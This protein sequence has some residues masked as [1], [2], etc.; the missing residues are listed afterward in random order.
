MQVFS[1]GCLGVTSEVSVYHG[2]AM[3]IHITIACSKFKLRFHQ[4]YVDG[5]KPKKIFDHCDTGS[6]QDSKSTLLSLNGW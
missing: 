2:H 4:I 5:L 1:Q 6:H 3:T